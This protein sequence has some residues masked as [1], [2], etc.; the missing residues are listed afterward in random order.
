MVFFDIWVPIFL[1][2][3]ISASLGYSFHTRSQRLAVASP[4]LISQPNPRY[5]G[6]GYPIYSTACLPPGSQVKPSYIPNIMSDCFWIINEDLLQRHDLLFQNLV[7]RHR[8]FE[9][10]S[11]KQYPSFW[12][13]GQ[14][15]ILV[16][17]GGRSTVEVLQ[18]FNIV[19]SAN[20]ILK[21]CIEGKRVPQGG[22]IPIGAIGLFDTGFRVM[23][24]GSNEI[25]AVNEPKL[26]SLSHLN[27]SGGKTKSSLIHTTS[28]AEP[29]TGGS[30]AKQLTMSQPDVGIGKRSSDSHLPL[31]LLTSI[32]SLKPGGAWGTSKNVPSANLSVKAPPDHEVSCFNPYS[33]K[34]QP[35]NEEDCN[36]VINEIILRYPNPMLE[37]TFGYGP[38]VD[39]DLSLP[40]N[41]KWIY[42]CCV[43]FI[44]NGLSRTQTAS[45]R[46]VDVALSAHRIVGECIVGARYPLGG[47]VDIGVI[48]DGFYVGAGGLSSPGNQCG[49]GG[50][51]G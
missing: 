12:Q 19:L 21:E 39:F 40:E 29:S 15:S 42:G 30:D 18:L 51:R 32:Q 25:D 8:N 33:V 7:F 4:T 26:S 28:A 50:Y 16:T 27:S 45:F 49:S 38:S 43:I 5:Q 9:D 2:L 1:I 23:V 36:F 35:A 46:L 3:N 31:S 48:A 6:N 11:G 13:H 22:S 47:T 14:C 20:K 44:R 24:I 37:Q 10:Q 41:E 17:N 34:L